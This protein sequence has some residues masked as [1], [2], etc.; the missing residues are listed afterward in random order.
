MDR[1]TECATEQTWRHFVTGTRS[2]LERDL[3]QAHA[4]ICSLSGDLLERR[5][6]SE[7]NSSGQSVE[8]PRM[9]ALGDRS[10]KMTKAIL[11]R[12]KASLADRYACQWQQ[13]KRAGSPQPPKFFRIPGSRIP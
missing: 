10:L 13:I 7:S 1:P 2:G 5:I 3:M 4:V 9:S 6:Q 11:G 12:R 8:A